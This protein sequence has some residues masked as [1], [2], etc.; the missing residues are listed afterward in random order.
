M[1]P[2]TSPGTSVWRPTPRACAWCL[3]CVQLWAGHRP[4]AGSPVEAAACRTGGMGQSQ[5]LVLVQVTGCHR[6]MSA[7]VYQ[8]VNTKKHSMQICSEVITEHPTPW[9]AKPIVC[10]IA[11]GNSSFWCQQQM[12][13]QAPSSRYRW[14]EL[15][16]KMGS[17]VATS[18]LE[19]LF[20]NVDP[21]SGS[22]S[23]FNVK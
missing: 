5:C 9:G 10:W 23:N 2:I 20:S 14:I 19:N 12:G 13:V 1:S 8:C 4:P 18:T 3:G 22:L 7:L 17:T 16:Q 6:S 11:C 21:T 15:I